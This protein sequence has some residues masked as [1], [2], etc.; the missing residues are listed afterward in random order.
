[1]V[2]A[3]ASPRHVLVTTDLSEP[4]GVAV[5]RAAQL[6][7]EHGARLTTLH[8][9]PAGMSA[10]IAHSARS[11]VEA[12][13]ARLLDRGLAATAAAA[14]IALRRGRAAVEITAEAAQGAAQ[15]VVIGASG[16][17]RL[18]DVLLGS[19]A[20][21]V[22]RMS[23]VPVLIVKRSAAASYHTVILA[24]DTTRQSA[25]A[26]RFGCGLAPS[27]EHIVVHACTV[28]GENLMR[29]YG[30]DDEQV[31]DL[32]Q[33]ATEEARQYISRLTDTLTPR[34]REVIITPGHPPTRLAEISQSYAA[35]LVVVGTGARS[36]VSYTFMG[37]VAQH[38]MRESRSDVLV[39]PTVDA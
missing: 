35:D 28:V 33:V 15:L 31:D 30:A 2:M 6:A 23:P 8:V 14:S 16:E 39:V 19:T 3:A 22:V 36:P 20:E 21:N 5:T 25:D 27:A 11:A 18:A 13:V 34:P 10:D 37:S 7:D 29:I 1:M 12:H 4:A 32:R 9:V 38:V 26:A 17:R 24:V